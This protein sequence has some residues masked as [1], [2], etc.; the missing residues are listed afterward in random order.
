MINHLLDVK[1]SVA[2]LQEW[3]R[4]ADPVYKPVVIKNLQHAMRK[5]EELCK[6]IG[7]GDSINLSKILRPEGEKA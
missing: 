7:Y 3:V 5:E 2:Y 4:L 1:E 6:K